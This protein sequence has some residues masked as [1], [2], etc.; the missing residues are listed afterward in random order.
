MKKILLP[1][2]LLLNTVGFTMQAETESLSS[3]ET[4]GDSAV[5][6]N[7][8]LEEVIVVSN[9]KSKAR[10]FEMPASVSVFNSQRIER[11]NLLSIKDFSAIAPNFF[12]PDYGSK[13]TTAIYIRGIGT[14]T[15]NS[16]VGMYVDNVPYLDKSIFDFDFLDIERLEILRG[17]QSTL[18]G[19][20]TM[21]GLINIYTKS[22]FDHQYTKA[23]VSYGNYNSFRAY[24]SRYGK[25][26][27]K[28]AY[29]LSGQYQSNDGY[30]K[31]EYTGRKAD[32]SKSGNGR[33]Q[34]YWRPTT[35]MKVNLTTNYEY[36]TQ[37]G[38]PYGLLNTETG[39][40]SPVYY[41]DPG[42]Y[43]RSL[44]ATSLYVE[45]EFTHFT[46]TN[47]TGY[48]FFD[49]HMKLDQDFTDKSFFTLNQK[50]KQHSATHE[51]VF[52]SN[53][54]TNFKWLAGAFGFYQSLNTD[55]PVNFKKEG[56]DQMINGNIKI[57]PV[58]IPGMGATV[59]L[60]DSLINDNMEIAGNFKTPTWGL[61]GYTQL[62]YDN[63]FIEGLSVSAGV[64]LDYEKAKLDYDSYAT[65]YAKG[66][67]AMQMGPVTRPLA[68]FIDTLGIQIKGKQG[69][70]NLEVLPRFDI[71]YTPNDKCMAYATVAKGYRA[72]GFNFQM[73]SD[74]IRDQLKS[75]MIGAFIAQA[76]K[77]GMG[78]NISDE[79][80]DMAKLP[81]FDERA[82]IVYKPEYSWNYE[83]G[84]RAEVLNNKLF[85]D[86]AAFYIDVRNQQVSSFSEEGLGR[87]TKNS[88]KSR[89]M[90]VEAGVRYFP[91]PQLAFSANYGYTNAKFVENAEDKMVNGK[92]E[93][94]D[95]KDKFVPFAPKHTL[96][97]AGNYL[98]TLNKSWIDNMNFNAQYAGGGRLYW[99][100]DNSQYQ[101]FY[102]TLSAKISARKGIVEVA[103]WGKN[104]TSAKYNA[105][106]FESLGK[107]L[108]QKGAPLTF[109]GE[110]TVRF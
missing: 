40:V 63:L 2:C 11:E 64:R 34:L 71:R 35:D 33:F 54:K 62:T 68:A 67:V 38:Y 81:P 48:Q 10:T 46:M 102:G 43:K 100:E 6:K 19:R 105:F 26:N 70:D 21:A 17:P 77:M 31:N 15:N 107:K 101:N 44:S 45:N 58:T 3:T 51:I 78:G 103:L 13:L 97:V 75:R 85:I 88:G 32:A 49:D 86:L 69:L 39:V 66:S 41:N 56:I 4:P 61:A 8:L 27:E 84:T 52:K 91:L 89:S 24:L 14:R 23:S 76:D 109:G 25:I 7:M 74:A 20:N 60:T 98:L 72:G 53:K 95:Y 9:P 5:F 96:S 80:R 79:V 18:Y 47:S 73:F 55:A 22:P 87:I 57:P 99:T 90:G 37:D 50:Q 65:A 83:I 93:H 42:S 59:L 106:Y 29:S 108:A 30:F 104:L 1:T 36:T 110:I 12:I 16:V 92:I 94:I 28:L 82:A